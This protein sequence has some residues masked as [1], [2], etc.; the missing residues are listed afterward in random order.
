MPALLVSTLFAVLIGGAAVIR[1]QEE[2]AKPDQTG[3]KT[4]TVRAIDDASGKAL[5]GAE[6]SFQH[7]VEGEKD[8]KGKLA[9]GAEGT[10]KIDYRGGA[11]IRYFNFTIRKPGY[12]PVQVGWSSARRPIVMPEAKEM[13]LVHGRSLGGVAVD[14]A[15]KPVEGAAVE[16]SMPSTE[17]DTAHVYF[18]VATAKT[19]AQGRWRI[20]DAPADLSQVHVQVEHPEYRRPVVERDLKAKSLNTV[21]VKGATVRGRVVGPDGRPVAG[22]GVVLGD[23][24]WGTHPP[25]AKT[26]AD[27]AFV[28]DN[29]EPGAASLTVQ[30][31]GFA[32]SI[33]SVAVARGEE[34]PPV[35][36]TLT[37]GVVLRGRV[38]GRDGKPLEGVGVMA[39]GWRGRRTI[40][41]RMTT[42]AEGRFEWKNA[43]PDSVAFNVGRGGLMGLSNVPLAA[44]DKE[45]VLVMAT[46]LSVSGSVVDAATKQ[47]IPRFRVVRG[48]LFSGGD[49]PAWQRSEADDSTEGRYSEV[50]DQAYDGWKLRIEAPGYK[51]VESRRIAPHE[52]TVVLDFSLEPQAG[53]TG[54]VLLPDGKLAAGTEVALGTKGVYTGLRGALFERAYNTP[55]TKADAEGRFFFPEP[56]VAYRLFAAAEA[57]FAEVDGADFPKTKVLKLAPWGRIEGQV[58]LGKK[59]GAG[60]FVT[61]QP[62]RS[63]LETP[64]QIMTGFSPEV[65]ADAEG[66]FIMEKVVPM[67]GYAGRVVITKLPGGMTSHSPVGMTAVAVKPGETSRVTIGGDGRT[68]VGRVVLDGQPDAPVD[69]SRNQ[70]VRIRIKTSM[71]DSLFGRNPGAWRSYAGSFDQN[72]RFRAE[73]VPPG[74][75]E[76]IA[77]VD[78]PPTANGSPMAEQ[79]GSGTLVFEVPA[80]ELNK[81]V[82]IGDVKVKVQKTL[83]VGQDAPALDLERVDGPKGR[84]VLGDRKGKV[85]VLDF[86]ATWCGP[87][88]AE[89]PTL[90]EIEKAHGGDPR[91]EL[92]G[93]SCDNAGA[94][95][96]SYAEKQGLNWTQAFAGPM[97]AGA[98]EVYGV[99]GIPCTFVIG[100]DGR[101]LAKHLRGAQLKSAVAKAL[102]ELEPSSV[103]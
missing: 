83:E 20:E 82:D 89:M 101:I 12:V 14:E 21:L 68:V 49:Q 22:A 3:M 9:T 13:R 84:F 32:P 87:C 44:S 26:D 1:A 51:P 5:E 53:L 93:V 65:Q 97:G 81:P 103:R 33:V 37:Q 35:A 27:G 61:F 42:D 16:V 95:A 6:V 24:I 96:A 91:F 86:W 66:R 41:Y 29:A 85:V 23:E 45:H 17:S 2:P 88:I 79:L 30:A 11:K 99:W 38:V 40:D 56:D 36:V 78:R 15:G 48:I 43:P 7:F 60:E 31:D 19:D 57:G 71:L 77:S 34:T 74:F 67:P 28:L 50:F 73:D 90:K 102:A 39:D 69:W 10:T 76:A 59:P 72:G 47:A 25:K 52:G 63:R 98:A 70:P 54:V 58:M 64:G 55:I 46:R 62:D 8:F 94:I 18:T 80:G 100:S 4:L 92:V 75:Y